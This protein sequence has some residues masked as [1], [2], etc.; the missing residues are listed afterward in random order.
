MPIPMRL[1][2]YLRQRG[3]QFEIREHRHSASSAETARTANIPPH[4]LAKSVVVEDDAGC[5]MAVLPGDQALSLSDL[6]GLMGRGSLRLLDEDRISR[7]LQD[8]DRGA[9]PPFGMP[10]GIETVVDD[11][12]E[13]CDFV[14]AEAG[15][16]EHLLRMSH[17]QF[18]ELMGSSRHGRF[19]RL[20]PH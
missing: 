1:T 15:D 11:E 19:S 6:A 20:P 12:L 17:Q 4:Q 9:V 2:S 13:A 18:H 7:M 16:H 14:Y 10:W 3:T 8:C 5:F